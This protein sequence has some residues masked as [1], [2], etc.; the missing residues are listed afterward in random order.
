MSADKIV[1]QYLDAF[2]S[3]DFELAKRL[4]A[5]DFEFRG[6][7]VQARNKDEFFSSA[8]RLAPIVKGHHMLRQ[9]VDSNEVSSIFDVN[10]QTP[11]GKGAVT[12]SEWHKVRGEK[13]IYGRVI[14]DT[15]AFRGLVPAQ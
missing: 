9:W 6:P 15:T 4:V 12:M 13:L 7:F 14:L 2:Y 8:A 10:L 5:D 3:G 11:A 1:N